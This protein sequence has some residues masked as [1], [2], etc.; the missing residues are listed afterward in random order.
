MGGG[1]A[2]GLR[3]GP[4]CRSLSPAMLIFTNKGLTL[5]LSLFVGKREAIPPSCKAWWVPFDSY[6]K[7]L[8]V[9]L[10]EV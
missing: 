1:C 4:L 7:T 9:S 3:C 10:W 5:T 6:D 2:R 8:C